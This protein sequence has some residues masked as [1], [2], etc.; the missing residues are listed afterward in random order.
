VHVFGNAV[1][2][3]KLITICNKYNIKVIEDAAESLGTTYITGKYKNKHC[4][5]IGT[6]GCLSFNGNKIITTGAGGAI[7]TNKRSYAKKARH[8]I[9][10][11]KVRGYGYLHDQVGFNYRLPNLNAALGLSQINKIKKL[12]KNKRKLFLFYK[13]I[14]FKSVFFKLVQE[15]KDCR[16]NFWLQTILVNKNH[17]SLVDNTI[18]ILHKNK[19][20]VRP[21]WELLV[22]LK[23]YKK[24]PKM[25]LSI[26]KRITRRIINIPSSSFLI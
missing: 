13:K 9:A 1:R 24:N 25:D 22:N 26:S 17:S 19:I 3:E 14:F 4:G 10:N 16:S 21:G 11:A 23:F 8:L 6:L 7:I 2:L 5:T 15:P 20:Y 12:L 18:K